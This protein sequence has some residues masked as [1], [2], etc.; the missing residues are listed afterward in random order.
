MP[1][2]IVKAFAGSSAFVTDWSVTGVVPRLWMK[3][4][5][6]EL[7][8]SSWGVSWTASIGWRALS[9][10]RS[11]GPVSGAGAS[12]IEPVR[13]R[14]SSVSEVGV[15]PDARGPRGSLPGREG[16]RRCLT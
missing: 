1:S 10:T 16:R 11:R 7:V 14:S 13:V 2:G 3:I 9:V 8:C 4:V 5:N 6:V 12:A 15:K